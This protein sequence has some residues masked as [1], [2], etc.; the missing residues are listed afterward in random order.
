MRAIA[1]N[2]PFLIFTFLT[3]YHRHTLAFAKARTRDCQPWRSFPLN[4][5]EII[6][7]KHLGRIEYGTRN[8]Y[9]QRREQVP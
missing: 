1:I 3:D 2:L 8:V 4:T 9:V 6:L 7:L 5:A